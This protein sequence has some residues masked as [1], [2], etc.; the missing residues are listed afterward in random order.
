MAGFFTAAVRSRIVQFILDR[1]RYST[2]ENE[3]YA[4][5]IERLISEEIYIAA[6]PLHDGEISLPGSMR[7]LLFNEW[8][9]IKRWYRYQPLDYIKDYFGVKI[10]LYFAWLG[11]Y[12]YMLLLASVVGILCFIYSWVTIDTYQ[13]SRDICE[14]EMDIKMCPL[15]DYWCDYWD[16]KESC[17]HTRVT[18]LFDNPTT[19]FFAVF[20]SFWAT[21]FLELWKRY[22]A[23]ITHRWD[24]TGFDIHEEHPRPQYLARLAHV[25]KKT[26]NVVTNQV[27]PQVPFWRVKLP[28]TILSFSIVILLVALAFAAVLAVVL[29]RMSVL[30]ALSVYGE[31]VETGRAILFTTATAASINLILIIIFNYLYTILAEYLTELELLRTQTEFDDSFTLKIYLLQFVNYYASIFYIAFFK[32]KFIGYPGDYNRFFAYRQEECG[33]GGCLMELCIQLA[34]IM[35]GKQTMN[36]IIEMLLPKFYQ[37]L[38]TIRVRANKLKKTWSGTGKRQRWLRDLKLVE[39]GSRSLFPEYLEMGK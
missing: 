37:W 2:K 14:G 25:R 29:Y 15:C 27:E 9:A 12:T 32:G 19:V 13:P 20:M 10:G 4:F 23:E 39:W 34:I 21:I 17:L 6:Y 18:Y 3:D 30:A 16:L 11:F 24:L 36:S 8:A 28:A 33:F 38:N 22:S 31:S 1:K 26:V 35:V 5:G 7:Y